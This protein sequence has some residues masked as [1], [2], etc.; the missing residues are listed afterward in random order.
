M[1]KAFSNISKIS[2][3]Q[4]ECQS[5]SVEGERSTAIQSRGQLVMCQKDVLSH[6]GS[7]LSEAVIVAKLQRWCH[8]IHALLLLCLDN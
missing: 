1:F 8:S 4:G 5:S 6:A 7:W 2:L 3:Y